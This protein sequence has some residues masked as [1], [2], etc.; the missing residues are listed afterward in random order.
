MNRHFSQQDRQGRLVTAL[1]GDQLVLLRMDGSEEI[2]GSFEWRVEALSFNDQLDLSALLGTHAT[3]EI[4]HAA[5]LRAFDGIVCEA[6][7]RGAFEN[8]FRYDL[9]LRPWL[10]VASL[11]RNM[12]IFHNKSVIEIVE[13]VLS[14][15]GAMGNPHLEIVT[16]GAYPVLEY[17]VQ[18]GESDADFIRRQ[19]ERHGI[20]WSWKHAPG[21]HTLVL[22]DA[23]FQ[24]PEVP[25]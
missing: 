1:G 18:Y 23:T 25:G 22:S 13:E 11:R 15:Y 24:L 7:S 2:S 6:R 20:S 4:D 16:S 9:V 12:R 19:L 10:H 14:T 17:T 5:G 21:S 8:G 3:V